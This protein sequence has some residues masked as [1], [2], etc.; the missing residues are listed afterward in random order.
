MG[1]DKLT[2]VIL[3]KKTTKQ[4]NYKK[5]MIVFPQYLNKMCFK[6]NFSEEFLDI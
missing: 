1:A 3:A 2:E 4:N 5:N 6:I